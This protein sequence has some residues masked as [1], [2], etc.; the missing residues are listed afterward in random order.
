M[1][2]RRGNR[3]R[4]HGKTQRT[5]CGDNMRGATK[6]RRPRLP[7]PYTPAH[8]VGSDSGPQR[9]ETRGSG[10][11]AAT[12][13]RAASGQ[14][15][16]RARGRERPRTRRRRGAAESHGAH[17]RA[18]RKHTYVDR[19]RPRV[20]GGLGAHRRLEPQLQLL[21]HVGARGSRTMLGGR[22]GEGRGSRREAR[23][24]D[25]GGRGADG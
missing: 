14:R 11:A 4:Q 5:S 3:R 9:L 22:L 13:R 2:G 19:Q 17:P 6:A 21:A 24:A 12:A 7:S 23:R 18:L 25:S 15:R 10:L 16:A 20:D 8:N 1:K